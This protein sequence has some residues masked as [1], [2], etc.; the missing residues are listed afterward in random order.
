MKSKISTPSSAWNLSFCPPYCRA[1]NCGSWP[2]GI[3][4]SMKSRVLRHQFTVKSNYF[5]RGELYYFESVAAVE[6]M[7]FHLLAIMVGARWRSNHLKC[8][9]L[10]FKASN[11][12][13]NSLYTMCLPFNFHINV[14]QI[15]VT[16]TSYPPTSVTPW[17]TR[18]VMLVNLASEL[19]RPRVPQ[20]YC[21]EHSALLL[22]GTLSISSVLYN[23][24]EHGACTEELLNDKRIWA[25][26]EFQSR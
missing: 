3:Y 7:S 5:W 25:K 12:I 18:S 24:E 4:Y 17:Q 10:N 16:K 9:A 11:F 23:A 14:A 8:K 13:L 26:E 19:I 6:K 1:I 21:R 2:V 20:Y 22:G 15:K